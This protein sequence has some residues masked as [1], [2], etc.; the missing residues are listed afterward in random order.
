MKKIIYLLVVLM[1]VMISVCACDTSQDEA[2]DN[3]IE[4]QNNELTN[5]EE[6]IKDIDSTTNLNSGEKNNETIVEEQQELDNKTT[7]VIEKIENIDESKTENKLEEK[8]E[9]SQSQSISVSATALSN[10]TNAWGFVRQKNEAR[11]Q[12]AA[13]YTK[14]LDDYEGIYAGNSEEKVIYLTFDDGPGKYTEQILEVLSKYDVKATFFVTNQF[15]NYQH[16]ISEEYKQGHTIGIHTYSHKWSIYS[17][18]ETYL[19]D[20]NKINEIIRNQTGVESKIF[21]FPGGSSNTIS[22]NYNKGI[23]TSLSQLMTEKG[24]IYFDWNIDSGDT[25]KKRNSKE[26]IIK[27]IKKNLNGDGAYII[28]THDIRK[29]TLEALPEII[30]TAKTFGYEFAAISESTRA[31]HFEVSN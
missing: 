28:L 25:A 11:P 7:E 31:P 5:Q 6:N 15:P 2:N 29:N 26:D 17:D 19:D 8:A 16:L 24:Y 12:F 4:I 30:E 3:N 23:M 14:V 13:Q 10:K 9:T 27:N 20:F 22:K 18:V 1:L 21:R